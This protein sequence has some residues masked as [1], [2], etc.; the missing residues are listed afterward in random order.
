M[1]AGTIFV[2]LLSAFAVGILVYLE[3]KSRRS[4]DESQPSAPEAERD[5]NKQGPRQ[6]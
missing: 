4:Q 2:I 5:T 6:H 3:W 1:D